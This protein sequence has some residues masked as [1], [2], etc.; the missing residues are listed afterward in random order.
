MPALTLPNLAAASIEKNLK[1]TE[2]LFNQAAGAR[3][4]KLSRG[5][6]PIQTLRAEAT[7]QPSIDA[8]SVESKERP[9]IAPS[10]ILDIDNG[11]I[12]GFGGDLAPD[13]PGFGDTE[14]CD[15]RIELSKAAKQH[16]PCA[17][18]QHKCIKEDDT[19]A[20]MLSHSALAECRGARISAV[21]YLPE[22]QQTWAHSLKQLETAIPKWA[23]SEYKAAYVPTA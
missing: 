18:K 20:A 3:R 8:T 23:C 15:R 13:H 9:R 22:E 16:V 17:P 10:S 21:N 6:G 12:L 4:L 5:K 11:N 19:L 7:E 2:D 1:L 14:Y